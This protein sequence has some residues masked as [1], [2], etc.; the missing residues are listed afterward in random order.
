MKSI[1][2]NR[3]AISIFFFTYGFST[4]N[5]ISRL[6]EL[7]NIYGASNS[8]LGI[9]LL[10]IALGGI[11]SAS[12]LNSKQMAFERKK[13]LFIA[14]FLGCIL[15]TISPLVGGGWG[16]FPL[17]FIFGMTDGAKDIIMN[18]QAV[19]LENQYKKPLMSSF[20]A[21]FSISLFLG[22][23]S[24]TQFEKFGVSLFNHL[25]IV[26]SGCLLLMLW[27]FHYFPENTQIN[28]PEKENLPP[29]VS[30]TKISLF[31]GAIAFCG[32]LCDSAMSDWAGIYTTQVIKADKVSA[33]LALTVFMG[34]T[35]LGRIIGDFLTYRLGRYRLLF[36]NN[37]V[38]IIGLC[39]L[40]LTAQFYTALLGFFLVGLGI[41]TILPLVYSIAGD[42]K[43][44]AP[45]VS[46]A[47]ITGMGYAAYVVAPPVIGF[48][49]DSFSLRIGFAF[50]LCWLVCM[51]LFVRKLRV[52]KTDISNLSHNE[53]TKVNF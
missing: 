33:A 45:S 35:A 22:A 43:G 32:M 20:H 39:V 11:T 2:A 9:I 36:L 14:A 42:T 37:V 8:K 51:L 34:G 40:I 41:S 15:V 4:S 3:L 1:R 24:G 52:L 47:K 13:I 26:S 6:P 28:L 46:I 10:C 25:L 23:A 48:L 18:E 53:H 31:L 17:F 50:V 5:L 27:G 19:I 29:S 12:I 44:D 16:T 21:I 38:T 7:Q 30:S 49:A